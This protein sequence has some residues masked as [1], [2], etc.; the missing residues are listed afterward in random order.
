MEEHRSR[1]PEVAHRAPYRDE[2]RGT[3]STVCRV[4]HV[5]EAVEASHRLVEFAAIEEK[6]REVGFRGQRVRRVAI[7]RSPKRRI[8]FVEL[9]AEYENLAQRVG[10]AHR[11]RSL[12]RNASRIV[13][14]TGGC[15][16]LDQA[17][18]CAERRRVVPE[19]A[20][21]GAFGVLVIAA[22]QVLVGLGDGLAV[23]RQGP[24]EQ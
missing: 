12:E 10:D 19:R 16:H 18:A 6:L 23:H 2:L 9:P 20:S 22:T 1:A 13:V 14:F 17:P 11:F 4:V 8:G 21:E 7:D 5:D 24:Q 15:E 3:Q